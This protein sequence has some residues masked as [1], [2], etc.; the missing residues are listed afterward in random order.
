MPK[1][2]VPEP[3]DVFDPLNDDGRYHNF[4]GDHVPESKLT[5][6]VD[7]MDKHQKRSL[8]ILIREGVLTDECFININD[9]ST[10]ERVQIPIPRIV[11]TMKK[12]ESNALSMQREKPLSLR[13]FYAKHYSSASFQRQ[14][15]SDLDVRSLST[16]RYTMPIWLALFVAIIF[17]HYSLVYS[18]TD[19]LI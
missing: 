3:G 6:Y 7:A 14:H 9:A 15:R 5:D 13:I 2:I 8:L 19:V 18:A 16:G 12:I 4:H 11:E 1:A 10:P 17:E